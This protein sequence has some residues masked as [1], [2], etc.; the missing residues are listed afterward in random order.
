MAAI[1]VFLAIHIAMALVVPK[2]LR[3]MIRGR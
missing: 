1:V 3:A 2:G